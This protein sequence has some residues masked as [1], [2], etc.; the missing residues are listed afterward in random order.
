MMSLKEIMFK[1]LFTCQP[2]AGVPLE[3][4]VQQVRRLVSLFDS[5]DILGEDSLEVLFRDIVETVHQFD[6][7]IGHLCAH[8][9]QLLFRRKTQ[10]RHLLDQLAAL[11]FAGEQRSQCQ[12]FSENAT[13]S[14]ILNRVVRETYPKCRSCSCSQSMPV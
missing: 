5:H 8:V 6:C 12:K 7:V 13:N 3:K 4:F 2:L 9:I 11:S 1:C 10:Y 14:Y